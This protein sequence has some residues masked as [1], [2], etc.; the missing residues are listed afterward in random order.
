MFSLKNGSKEEEFRDNEPRK[1]DRWI[2][3]LVLVLII[4]IRDVINYILF[5]CNLN[6]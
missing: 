2:R 3:I 6:V 4:M 5:N 1:E